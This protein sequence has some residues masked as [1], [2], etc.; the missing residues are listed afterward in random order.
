MSK[1][2]VGVSRV[3]ITPKIGHNLS[4]WHLR[5]E[6]EKCVTPLLARA[7]VL[8]NSNLRVVLITCDLLAFHEPL[9]TQIR[10]EVA[11]AAGTKFDNVFL[12][13]SHNHFAA[14]IY[15]QIFTKEAIQTEMEKE[16]VDALPGKLA[17]CAKKASDNLQVALYGYGFG[18]EE[19]V[20]INSRFKRKDGLTNWVGDI[21]LAKE[22]GIVD[23]QLSVISFVDEDKKPIA[24]IFHYG[25]HVNCGEEDG[26]ASITWDWCG[27]AADTI[28]K[29][30]GGEALFILAP[31]GDIH[32]KEYGVAKQMG[33]KVGKTAIEVA[34]DIKYKSTDVLSLITDTINFQKRDFTKYDTTQIDDF[35][36]QLDDENVKK[37][38]KEVTVKA[39]NEELEEPL[40]TVSPQ[41]SAL[42]LGD[43]AIS[44]VPGELFV[45]LGMEIKNKSAIQPTL[46]AELVNDWV[47]YLP[48]TKD[49]ADGGYQVGPTTKIEPGSSE[50]LVEKSLELLEKLKG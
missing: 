38:I 40:G 9:S 17:T 13:P 4:G 49:Y 16:Y 42:L 43:I 50:M 31:C 41:I 2:Q 30:L 11:N 32:P 26:L 28:E 10:E 34:K 25:C 23:P 22:P 21:S 18:S 20:L 12:F 37:E 5:R 39:L 14:D 36:S 33:E 1:L 24:T 15:P 35:C 27:Y 7:L 44:N 3:D 46:V 8:D 45:K 47:S 48:T 6:A 19:D 29:A